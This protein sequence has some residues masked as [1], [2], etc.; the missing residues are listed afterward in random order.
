MHLMLLATAC[1]ILVACAPFIATPLTMPPADGRVEAVRWDAY[2][3]DVGRQDMA[4]TQ[5]K[6]FLRVTRAG[7]P[8]LD[9]SEGRVAKQ[10][11]EDYCGRYDRKLNPVAF[12]MF[13]APASWIFEGG[14]T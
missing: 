13:S 4:A 11:A 10:V 8:D 1:S 5:G 3:Y 14:C 2:T 6:M 9:Y 12:G 7:G